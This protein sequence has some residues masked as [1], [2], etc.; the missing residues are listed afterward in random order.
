MKLK[1]RSNAYSYCKI[2]NIRLEPGRVTRDLPV[3][4]EFVDK[5]LE[6]CR[7][8]TLILTDADVKS[9]NRLMDKAKAKP[10]EFSALSVP[11]KNTDPTG[12]Q[13]VKDAL[14]AKR[15]EKQAKQHAA[16]QYIRERE[17]R[18]QAESN[19]LDESGNPINDKL[20]SDA[21]TKDIKPELHPEMGNEI[22]KIMANNLAIMQDEKKPRVPDTIKMGLDEF[23]NDRNAIVAQPDGSRIPTDPKY[24]QNMSK[25][26]PPGVPDVPGAAQQYKDASQWKPAPGMP[27]T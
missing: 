12:M 3:I 27:A 1:N 15:I 7:G 18:V 11:S 16:M 10:V 17:A 8:F 14:K 2:A 25:T 4:R 13:A 20:V 24:Y 22:D 5:L 26:V 23:Q 19:M 6:S 21:V 9:I